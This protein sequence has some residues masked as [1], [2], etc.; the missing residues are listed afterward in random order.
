MPNNQR[1]LAD[2]LFVKTLERHLRDGNALAPL[3]FAADMAAVFGFFGLVLSV[4]GLYGVLA[5]SVNRRA[6]E[7]GVRVALGATPGGVVRL[8]VRQG[9][10][11]SLIGL[12]MGAL[13]ASWMTGLVAGLLVRVS[14]TDPLVFL[15]TVAVLLVVALAACYLPARR[16]LRV[17]PVAALRSE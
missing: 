1:S 15:A 10:A 3:R 5:F 8:V 4:V 16:A 7:I 9:L 13:L 17:D 11:L 6:H 2:R 12:A 14:P